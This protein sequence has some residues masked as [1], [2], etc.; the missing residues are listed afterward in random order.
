[1][2]AALGTELGVRT[3]V[4]HVA[5]RCVRQFR[6]VL[7]V[8]AVAVHTEEMVGFV[9]GD[10]TKKVATLMTLPVKAEHHCAV[11]ETRSSPRHW[12]VEKRLG[13]DVDVG[14]LPTTTMLVAPVLGE[15]QRKQPFLID[16]S[17]HRR[18]FDLLEGAPLGS[19]KFEVEGQID[20]LSRT[21]VYSAYN[22]VNC[23][24]RDTRF[25]EDPHHTVAPPV[26]KINRTVDSV[27][28]K[29]PHSL[30]SDAVDVFAK[31]I[32]GEAAMGIPCHVSLLL[33]NERYLTLKDSNRN[34]GL[35]RG[36]ESKLLPN[37]WLLA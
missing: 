23:L 24:A 4:V 8:V 22:E 15:R 30:T 34:C 19:K 11:F 6:D 3:G 16:L 10:A 5:P 7:V 25:P 9:E 37:Y 12:V 1:M 20:R 35:S 26:R 36:E 33:V 14:V 28:A 21:L 13:R 31:R 2:S 27:S 17:I 32:V 29:T 18:R